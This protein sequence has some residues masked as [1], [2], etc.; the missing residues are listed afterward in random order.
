M[1]K[2]HG[3]Y[4]TSPTDVKTRLGQLQPRNAAGAPV[5]P[6]VP[7]IFYMFATSIKSYLNGTQYTMISARA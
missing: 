3:V 5:V 1:T 7:V 6:D 2:N 4:P